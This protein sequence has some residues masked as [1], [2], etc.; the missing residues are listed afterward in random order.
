MVVPPRAAALAA[1]PT[2][3]VETLTAAAARPFGYDVAARSPRQRVGLLLAELP[4]YARDRVRSRVMR[5]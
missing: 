3:L 4:R 1:H 5:P 2:A